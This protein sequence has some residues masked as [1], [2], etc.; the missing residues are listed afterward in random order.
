MSSHS[1]VRQTV[2]VQLG[3]RSYDIVIGSGLLGD[4]AKLIAPLLNRPKLAIITDRAVAAAHLPALQKALADAQ[5]E[6]DTMILP[7]GEPTKS[8][9]ELE[10]VCDWL[11][12]KKIER[13]DCI[14]AF[15]GGVIGD[16]TGFAAAVLR[17]GTR[18]IQMPTSLLAQVDS[19][20]G[21]KTAIN[22]AQGKNLIGAFHQPDLVLADTDV[23]AS[24][25]PRQLAAGYAEIVK[26]GALGYADFFAWLEENGA[27]VLALEPAAIT[28]AIA[29]SCHAKADIVARDERETGER[30]LLNLGHTFGHAFEALCGY[31]GRLLHG[32]AVALGMVMAFDFS[33]ARGHCAEADSVRLRQVLAAAG[34]PVWMRD[35]AP[36]GF[37][38]TKLVEAMQQDKKVEAG[39]MRFI[40]ARALGDSF[41]ANDVNV[42]DLS[43][44][45]LAN[46]AIEP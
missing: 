46:G 25:P 28:H 6:S 19:S 42:P 24:L 2:P 37:A 29:Q 10:R 5:I 8:F 3:N 9:G 30:A 21:G 43:A 14:V 40:L 27:S 23:L 13:N 31:G 16:L 34:L 12:D 33:V 20:I 17:R 39:Q 7:E 15:G 1:P 45:L 44:F 26:Y 32:E 18:F 4:A 38:V 35:I 41:I 22:V 36:D 11:L